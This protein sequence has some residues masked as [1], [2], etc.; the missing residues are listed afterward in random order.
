M[1]AVCCRVCSSVCYMSS[2]E[3]AGVKFCAF[4]CFDGSGDVFVL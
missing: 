4:A 2:N 1:N 3:G